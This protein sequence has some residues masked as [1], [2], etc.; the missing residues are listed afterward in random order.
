MEF[1]N[2]R[3]RLKGDIVTY[4]NENTTLKI[5]ISGIRL[6]IPFVNHVS[7]KIINK[8]LKAATLHLKLVI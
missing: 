5:M 3:K 2:N 4:I 6:K 8:W 7:D 1:I